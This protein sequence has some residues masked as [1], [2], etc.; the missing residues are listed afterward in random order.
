MRICY[1]ASDPRM[2]LTAPTGYGS[3]IRKT[4]AAFEEQ[5]FD[6]LKIIAGD[7]RDITTTRNLYRKFGRPRSRLVQWL[8][9]AA[10]DLHEVSDDHLSD[11]PYRRLIADAPCDLLYERMA[12][13]RSS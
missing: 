1:L 10:R 8:K 6:V 2:R 3:H 9:S 12:P 11:F 4:I 5:K 7:R 13:F